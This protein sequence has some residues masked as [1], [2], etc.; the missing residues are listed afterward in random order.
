MTYRR[1]QVDATGTDGFKPSLRMK[2]N[3]HTTELI[4]NAILRLDENTDKIKKC[5]WELTEEEIWR[6]PNA[7]SNSVGNLL[8][9]LCGNI[10]QYAISSLGG[11]LD[12][13]ERDAEFSA[14]ETGN[15][16]ELFAKLSG[17]VEEAITVLKKLNS[18]ELLRVRSV[19]GYTFSGIG[20]VMHVV[21]HYSYHTGQIAFWTKLLR[22]QDLGFYAKVDLNVKN[23]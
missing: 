14:R 2:P 8:L 3:Q 1:L 22:D 19:Q 9:H 15:K 6:R 12:V 23:E 4:Q 18:E 11:K 17:T 20:I 10:R 13:R 21:E 16:S 7:A 5:L